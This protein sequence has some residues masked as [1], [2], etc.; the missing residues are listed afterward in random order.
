MEDQTADIYQKVGSDGP[1]YRLVDAFYE[2][3]MQDSVIRPMY[4]FDL[5]PGKKH[6]AQFLIQRFGGPSDYSNDRGHPRLRMRHVSF[7]I[8]VTERDAWVHHM[9]N[10]VLTVPEFTPYMSEIME[11]FDSTATFM[12]NSE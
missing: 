10:A 2:G 4:P 7:K 8:G 6:L 11:Y 3:V 12:I 5:E 1:F 9:R